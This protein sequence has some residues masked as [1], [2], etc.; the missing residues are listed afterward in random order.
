MFEEVSAGFIPEM[1]YLLRI[2]LA[3][4]LGSCIG[5]ER[6]LRYKEAG[7]RTHAIVTGGA[8]LI[9]IVS[10]Y[11]F[12]SADGARVA[13]QIVTGIGFLGAGIIMYKR[14]ALRGLTTAAGIWTAAGVGMAVGAGLYFVGIGGA[15][16]L[17]AFQCVLHIKIKL[18]ETRLFYTL[19][20]KF[21]CETDENEFVKGLFEVKRYFKVS[22]YNDAD[23]LNVVGEIRTGKLYDDRSIKEIITKNNYIK[24]IERIED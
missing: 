10:K 2:F 1:G 13:A 4:F 16:L 18:F 15:V 12:E 14:E 7:M 11:G 3:L 6:K 9:V 19:R 23:G 24:S 17:I 5:L 21:K 20:I 22:Y 8:A